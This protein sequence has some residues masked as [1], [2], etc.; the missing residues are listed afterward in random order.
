[1]ATHSSI[2]AWRIPWTEEPGGL[3]SSCKELDTTEVSQHACTHICLIFKWLSNK[4][5][6][7]RNCHMPFLKN[8][9]V[10]TQV[11]CHTSHPFKVQVLVVFCMFTELHSCHLF[12][13][14]VEILI[15]CSLIRTWAVYLTSVFFM[16]LIDRNT[17]FRDWLL[18]IK[19]D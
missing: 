2:L 18:R 16:L 3:Q 13:Y 15:Q 14:Q 1:M 7:V 4:I 19:C 5:A 12:I 6:Q 8:S 9:S 10:E 11:V 17:F